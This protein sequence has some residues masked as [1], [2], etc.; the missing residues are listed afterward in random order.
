LTTCAGGGGGG[1]CAVADE[2]GAKMATNPKQEADANP[3]ALPPNPEASL[4]YWLA[5]FVGF[6]DNV[7]EGR[8]TL[9]FGAVHATATHTV[10][11]LQRIQLTFIVSFEWALQEFL[12]SEENA[13]KRV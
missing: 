9:D 12:L 8:C 1:V 7:E 13:V 11:G 5:C 3:H 2:S 10:G 6:N 4:Q